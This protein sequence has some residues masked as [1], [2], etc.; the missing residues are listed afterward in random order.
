LKKSGAFFFVP[1]CRTI[2]AFLYAFLLYPAFSPN[3][4]HN[5]AAAENQEKKF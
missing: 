5:E 1:F 2:R 3:E 4:K